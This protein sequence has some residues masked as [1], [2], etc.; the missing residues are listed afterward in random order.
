VLA[1]AKASNRMLTHEQIQ[2]LVDESRRIEV[3]G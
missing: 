2:R 1:A 3:R